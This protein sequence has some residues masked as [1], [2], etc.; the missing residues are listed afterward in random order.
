MKGKRRNDGGAVDS[1]GTA[2]APIGVLLIADDGDLVAALSILF[3]LDERFTV[4][5][6]VDDIGDAA[7]GWPDVVVVDLDIADG[8]PDLV[9]DLRL[10]APEVKLVAISSFPDPVTLLG[11][12]VRGADA[13]L[14]RATAWTDLIPTV[15]ELCG[16][17]GS[18]HPAD[19]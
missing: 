10:R 15:C 12:L 13:Y 16:L 1:L 14:D 9:R 18:R 7:T 19:A 5:A 17:P 2:P 11:V 8:G 6:T 4:S 3:D